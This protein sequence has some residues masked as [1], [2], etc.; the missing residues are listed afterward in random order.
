MSLSARDKA[1]LMAVLYFHPEK[2]GDY[3]NCLSG[4]LQ[5][6][7]LPVYESLSSHS[8]QSLRRVAKDQ[9]RELR[10]PES[11][12]YLH[13]VHDDWLV[14]FL[15]QETPEMVALILRNLPGDRIK[16]LLEKMPEDFKAKLPKMGETFALSPD[17]V[18]LI[19]KRFEDSFILDRAKPQLDHL[20]FEDL[21]WVDPQ[22]LQNVFKEAGYREIAIAIQTVS[23]KAQQV[24]L[25]RLS[26]IDRGRVEYHLKQTGSGATKKRIETAQ[27]HL[28][29]PKVGSQGAE[30][31]VTSLGLL[32]YAKCLL[33]RDLDDLTIIKRKMAKPQAEKLQRFVDE[34]VA[35]QSEATVVE[36]R[37]EILMAMKDI[38]KIS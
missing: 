20:E 10:E 37:H 35:G 4:D 27:N 23:Q 21:V 22:S 26:V 28:V 36:F 19:Q 9:M 13:H 31:F 32:V 6:D 24:I 29:H 15:I 2:A 3:I 7:I 8:G 5:K 25:E 16:S 11:S 33:A 17:L 38:L 14:S 1:F 30:D 18:Q 34:A 12:H